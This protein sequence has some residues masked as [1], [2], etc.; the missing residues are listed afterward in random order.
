M[1][2]D[3]EN[4]DNNTS[5]PE[6]SNA[7]FFD[8]D[9][10]YS[11]VESLL[12][13]LSKGELLV[14]A[15]VPDGTDFSYGISPSAG[16]LLRSTE[17]W[18]SAVDEYGEGPELTFFSDDLSWAQSSFLGDVRGARANE[19][20]ILFV[21]KNESIVLCCENGKIQDHNGK[22][23]SYEL[24]SIA[25]HED[26]LF[27]EIPAGVER[28]DWFTN[29]DQDVVAVVPSIELLSALEVFKRRKSRSS[30]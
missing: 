18:Q 9:D 29:K 1:T 12:S 27:R 21:R 11:S 26:P 7:L 19:L 28:G 23:I 2:S 22:I 4:D 24:C 14:H 16:M 6:T 8:N 30:P 15:R 3:A 20:E 17:S 13:G 25:D 5:F 10:D